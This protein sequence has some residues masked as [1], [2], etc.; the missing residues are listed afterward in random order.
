[1]SHSQRNAGR[2]TNR[3]FAAPWHRSR[4]DGLARYH[5]FVSFLAMVIRRL[6][7]ALLSN[8][9]AVGA[10]VLLGA[11]VPSA[12]A[13]GAGPF[14]DFDWT[15]HVTTSRNGYAM[16]AR[17]PS[18]SYTGVLPSHC[19]S[20]GAGARPVVLQV[21]CRAPSFEGS[22]PISPTPAHGC[23]ISTTIRFSLTP[24]PCSIRCTG[25]SP[26][27]VSLSSAGLRLRAL[28]R[29]H[30]SRPSSYAGARTTPCPVRDWISHCPQRRFSRC[31]RPGFQ[32]ASRCVVKMCQFPPDLPQCPNLPKRPVRC[33]GIAV[34]RL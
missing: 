22:S 34:S 15:D 1:M 5:P 21:H 18:R 12:L 9:R 24:I 25:S 32:S 20:V 26:S 33:V 27:P 14:V 31:T 16:W 17:L 30:P 8:R 4:G 2:H 7:T 6:H 11:I 23:S 13:S 28:A 3:R 19:D 10:L 29:H